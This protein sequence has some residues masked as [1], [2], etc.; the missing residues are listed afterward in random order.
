VAASG[1]WR[2]AEISAAAAATAYRGENRNRWRNG[3]K[4]SIVAK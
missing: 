2:K 4:K 3:V 1:N